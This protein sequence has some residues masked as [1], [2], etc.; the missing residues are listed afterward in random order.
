MSDLP[1]VPLNLDGWALLHQL[2][3]A[4][5]SLDLWRPELATR[6]GAMAALIGFGAVL[7]ALGHL[8]FA[9]RDA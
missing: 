3:P 9:R 1:A 8:R 2:F 5:H 6:L 4:A 7:F